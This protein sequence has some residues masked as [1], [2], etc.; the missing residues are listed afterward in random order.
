MSSLRLL[1]DLN[2]LS[3]AFFD[4]GSKKEQAMAALK[5]KR[6]I[7][8]SRKRKILLRSGSKISFPASYDSDSMDEEENHEVPHLESR[9][10]KRSRTSP[11][12]F[13]NNALRSELSLN[14]Q[15][16]QMAHPKWAHQFKRYTSFLTSQFSWKY[17]NAMEMSKAGFFFS[18]S[19]SYPS[20]C[21]CFSCGK[22]FVEWAE[23]DNPAL[24]HEKISPTC[25]Y[26]QQLLQSNKKNTDRDSQ[27]FLK[28]W[29]RHWRSRNVK[30][31]EEKPSTKEILLKKKKRAKLIRR[32]ILD[33]CSIP[34]EENLK[35]RKLKK[36]E[37]E[38]LKKV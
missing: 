3:Q 5:K 13:E 27:D 2:F 12:S 20:R 25:K 18:P 1:D 32:M 35:K 16:C 19:K 7:K 29:F 11:F 6:K 38:K 28:L 30:N 34:G 21:V 36:S 31:I 26:V 4:I 10:N 22:A 9:I 24:V 23:N 14:D 37:P 17:N 8:H 33:S 15:F